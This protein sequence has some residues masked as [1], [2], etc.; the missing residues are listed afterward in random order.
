MIDFVNYSIVYW[1]IEMDMLNFFMYFCS[2]YKH[3]ITLGYIRYL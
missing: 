3:S 2:V 1:I